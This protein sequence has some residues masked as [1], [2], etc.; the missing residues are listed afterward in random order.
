M[1]HSDSSVDL[2]IFSIHFA[3]VSSLVGGINLNSAL[4]LLTCCGVVK[5]QYKVDYFIEVVPL[6]DTGKQ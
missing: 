6:A 4:C 2:M 1:G 5:M 3:G